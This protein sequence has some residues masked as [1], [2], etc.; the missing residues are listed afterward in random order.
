[1]TTQPVVFTSVLLAALLSGCA[2]DPHR[3]HHEGGQPMAHEHGAMDMQSM[4][5]MH[6]QMFEGKTAAERQALVDEHMKSMSPEMRE[7]MQA[8]MRQCDESPAGTPAS[9]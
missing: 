7:H 9:R 3:A 1:M 6:R 8:M 5:A 4:C 2:G